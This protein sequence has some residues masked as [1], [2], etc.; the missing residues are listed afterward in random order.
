MRISHRSRRGI[1][2][3]AEGGSGLP[4]PLVARRSRFRLLLAALYG[5]ATITAGLPAL[6]DDRLP[7]AYERG[8]METTGFLDAHPDVRYRIQGQDALHAGRPSVALGRFRQ[9]ALYADKVSQAM[10]AEMLWKG[11][12]AEIDRAFAYAWMDLAAERGYEGF[13][14]HRERYWARLDETERARAIDIGG[15][16]YEKYGDAVARPRLARVMHRARQRT[17]GGRISM[18]G[19]Y[20]DLF[21]RSEDG[22]T[23]VFQMNE[24]YSARLWDESRY[25][26]IQ[27]A[28]WERTPNVDVRAIEQVGDTESDE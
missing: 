3:G 5:A 14:V 24:Y 23:R 6:A 28:R 15:S 4:G 8:V 22:T 16:L 19:R 18:L 17:V 11:E 27:D 10:I 9:A 26:A 7:T 12:G 21:A 13:V 20:S 25:Q 1:A 2:P